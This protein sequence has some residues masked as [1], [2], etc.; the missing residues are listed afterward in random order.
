MTDMKESFLKKIAYKPKK[1]FSTDRVKE[2]DGEIDTLDSFPTIQKQPK[3]KAFSQPRKQ[4][5][6]GS[7][8]SQNNSGNTEASSNNRVS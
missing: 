4:S 1:L 7:Q 8:N 2:A 3:T 5:E 6:N